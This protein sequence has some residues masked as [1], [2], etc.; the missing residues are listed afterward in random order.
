M[1]LN[2][3]VHVKWTE[4][5]LMAVEKRHRDCLGSLAD[6]YPIFEADCDKDGWSK[7]KLWELMQILGPNLTMSMKV[8]LIEGNTIRL[9]ATAAD[10]E[11]IQTMR[12]G[13]V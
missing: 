5:G 10:Q 6:C 11:K 13:E 2:N 12:A 9:A 1:N 4:A 8:P 7:L 3:T